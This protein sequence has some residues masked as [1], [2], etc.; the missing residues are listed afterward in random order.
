MVINCLVCVHCWQL[1][2]IKPLLQVNVHLVWLGLTKL[3]EQMLLI[4]LLHVPM[5]VFVIQP[6][7]TVHVLADLLVVL[8]KEVSYYLIQSIYPRKQ[9]FLFLC[10]CMPQFL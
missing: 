8:V 9:L 6:L 5:P 1:F 7:E 2:I 4:N 10:R 3:M